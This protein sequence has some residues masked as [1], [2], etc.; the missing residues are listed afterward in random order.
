MRKFITFFSMALIATLAWGATV[1]IDFSAQGFENAQEITSIE[2]DGITIT[3]DKGTNSTAPKYYNVGAALRLYGSNT[4]TF[5]TSVNITRVDFTFDN[6]TSSATYNM[7]H[8]QST[9]ATANVGTYVDNDDKVSGVWTGSAKSFTITSSTGSG[10]ARIKSV[11]VT[12]EGTPEVTMSKP[13]I[14]PAPGTYYNPFDVTI[15]CPT[16]GSSVYYTLDG[17]NPTTSSTLYSAPIKISATT[18]VK[19]IGALDGKV[20]DVVTAEYVIGSATPVA[21]IKAYQDIADNTVVKFSNPVTVLG[22]NGNSLYVKDATGYALFYGKP[23]QNYK[24]GDQIPAGFTGK[25]VTYAG[26]PELE[27]NENDG[28]QAASGNVETNPEN[29]Q[30]DDVAGDLFA[31]YVYIAGATLNPRTYIIK[32]N[33]GEAPYYTGMGASTADSTK[34]YNVW[35]IIG[36]REV[37]NQIIYRVLPMKIEDVNGGGGGE[38]GDVKTIA[39]YKALADNAEFK[40]AGKVTVT[41]RDPNDQR[42]LYIKDETGSALIYGSDF[43]FMQ[44]DVLAPG[45]SGKKSN[46]NGL[47]EITNVKDLKTSGE[48]VSVTPV[49]MNV[50]DITVDNQNIY[51]VLKGVKLESVNGR[52]FTFVGGAAG[53]NTFNGTVTLPS[54]LTAT[55]D[56]EGVM[57]V[58]RNNPQFIPTRF[59]GDI[60]IPEVDDIAALYNLNAGITATIKADVKAVFQS[61]YYLYIQDANENNALVYGHLNESFTNG[62]VI[63]G[64]QASWSEYQGVKQLSPVGGTFVKAETGTPVEPEEYALEDISQEDVHKYIVINEASLVND[65]TNYYTI[66]DGTIPMV[67]FNKYA[68]KIPEIK[69]DSKYIV[70]AFVTVFKGQIEL[71]PAEVIDPNAQLVGDVDG[72]GVINV[73]DVTALVNMILDVIPKDM[74]RGDVDGNGSINVSDVTALVNIILGQ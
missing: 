4:I 23:G 49:E 27:I 47:Y 24:T 59:L 54:D 56:I 57:G 3:L 63:K 51:C 6:A 1:T 29:I 74:T 42:Y 9:P 39:E 65:S 58:N 66:N 45:W 15:T 5:E 46:Y 18:T 38:E 37:D 14:S 48:N 44:G 17:S 19:A 8:G 62:D 50:S 34:T 61:G 60:T 53:Y 33:S 40:F 52:N 69:A 73:S 72:N 31:H 32:D 30:V 20:S 7:A 55:Y 22:H 67:L 41:Y 16:T 21:N 68:V 26:E 35:A 64:A 25:K 12:T 2:Q 36:S 28:F 13:V 43:E 11:V 10:H 70:K 71:Y